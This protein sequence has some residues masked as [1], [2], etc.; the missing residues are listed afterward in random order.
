MLVVAGEDDS[1]MEAVEISLG[2][3]F[4]QAAGGT[5]N[6]ELF[7]G[8]SNMTNW[9]APYGGVGGG[10]AP[11]LILELFADPAGVGGI[12]T[13]ILTWGDPGSGVDQGPFPTTN[14]G[15]NG[16]V[17]T[18]DAT[19]QNP[20]TN[21]YQYAVHIRPANPAVDKGWNAFKMRAAGTVLL[22]GNQVVAFLGAM[23]VGN[24]TPG[25]PGDLTTIYPDIFNGS[26]SLA[27]SP[28]DGTW[29]F[30]T[31][32]PSFL[33]NVTVYDGD[34]DFGAEN[35]VGYNDSDDS[36]TP[37]VLLPGALG[38]GSVPEGV[39][40]ATG[41]APAAACDGANFAN[42]TRTGLP[43][44]DN[45]SP[46]YRRTPSI[47]ASG[48]GIAYR[49]VAPP[50]A[51]YP[52][53]QIFLNSNPSGNREWEQFKIQLVDDS[54]DVT[55]GACPV[56]GYPADAAKGYEASDC[57]T[58]ELPGGVWD[59]QLDGMDL[60]NLNFWFF[61]FKVE[62][63]ITEYSIG[64]LVWYDANSNQAQDLCAGV[65]CAPELGI[66]G[67]DYTVYYFNTV[68]QVDGAIARQGTTDANGEFLETGLPAGNYRVVVDASNFDPGG[69]LEGL[70]STTGGEIEN[71][72]EVG[73]PAC[74]DTNDPV[75]CGEPTYNEAIFGYVEKK[76]ECIVTPI[77]G[78][79]PFIGA[80]HEIVP[81]PAGAPAGAITVRTS[82]N[83]ERF[84]DNT[85]GTGAIGW[86]SGH[87]FSNLTGSDK[88]QLAL[89]DTNGVKKLE[90]VMDYISASSGAPGG[91]TTL[92]V[93]GGDGSFI[94]PSGGASN[95][96][97]VDTSLSVNFRDPVMTPKLTVN[98]PATNASYAPPAAP[99]T[100][101]IF[102]VWY[103]V[104]FKTEIFGQA[105]FG[106]A[107]LV[108][109]HAS[110]SKTGSNTEVCIYPDAPA[111]A[112][113][114]LY[115][116]K[117]NVNKVVAA[118]GV[119]GNDIPGGGGALSAVLFAAPTKG[120]LVGGLNANGSFTYK[121][122]KDFTGED[123]F[124]YQASNAN[125]L[126]N[127]ATVTIKVKK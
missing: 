35:C 7:D 125:G 74:I 76:V 27:G 28:Y 29:S 64:R 50:S 100:N 118:P 14:N 94:F 70:S 16:V 5:G 114:D 10:A 89:Y 20:V 38:V 31:R 123:K 18:H 85:Y 127:V 62:P 8:D 78:G 60:S 42:G 115:E 121:P 120:T 72:V 104:T 11:A 112:T 108:S 80:V 91:F 65:P 97:R 46:L 9:D 68:G 84:V 56:G 44:D 24:F 87:T 51:G 113:N 12:N 43:A 83:K 66:P 81:N 73:L 3:N 55:D 48:L 58:D 52:Q 116:T 40:A 21:N 22:L 67:V 101:W 106:D 4:T 111:V 117:K 110:P 39:A 59:I 36:D 88:M 19:A 25:N 26:F 126:S 75:D 102:D 61:S 15:W 90:F 124:T 47:N 13:P 86:P 82:L 77:K 54:G 103:D 32:L 95:I 71:G 1:T 93:S 2:L 17:F 49:L 37:N 92:G 41:N 30:K 63:I 96:W 107:R 23:N 69:P 109:V 45:S 105:G 34:M 122:N 98:S 119:L 53:G 33:D 6:F 79:T 99:Y 57:R